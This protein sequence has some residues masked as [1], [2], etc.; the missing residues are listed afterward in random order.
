VSDGV[1]AERLS[2]LD[3]SFLAVEG[4]TSPMHVGWVAAFDPPERGRRPSFDELLA[5]I[6]GRMGRAPRFRQKL[7]AVPLGVHDPV[8]VDDAAF[9]PAAHLLRAEG[10]KLDAVVDE[11]LSTPLRRDRP[12]WQITVADG[13][14]DGRFALIGKMHH[15]L[16]DG[17]AIVELGNLLLDPEPR[18]RRFGRHE[19]EPAPAP[20]P[21][22]RLGRAIADRIGD[23]AAL[24]VA[25]ARLAS[26]AAVVRGARTL[27]H[28]VLPPARSSLLNRPGSARRHHVRVTRSLD[29]VRAVRRR[30]SVT[31]NDVALAACAGA[32]RRFA[33]RRGEVA[34]PLKIMVPADVR[35]SEDAGTGNRISFVFLELPCH[36]P[37]PVQRLQRI[38]AATARRRRDG[39]A[40]GLDAAL[41]M[42]ARTP[43]PLQHA[44]AHAFAHPRLFN[45][46]IS[47]VP[48]PAV[49]RYL[50]G[51]RLREVWSA[52]P[53]AD[54]HAL[55]IG[56][57]T[58]AGTACFGLFADAETLPDADSL[59]ADLEAALDELVALV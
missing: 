6:A 38:G 1:T 34:A 25:P 13:L 19:W 4:P 57:V 11:V 14:E 42:L 29:E 24:A 3:A 44:L 56:V 27:A 59:G 28:V 32:L 16:V 36:E 53:L 15:C 39:D 18:G 48:G 30:F 45:L 7:A 50:R 47:S 12:L 31:P 33:E 20:T 2:P 43:G 5:H 17:A 37:D 10:A 51:C 49:P 46:T 26:P 9:D 58:V 52:V 41:G 40:D 23:A 55:S 8:W 21:G 54:R 22:V 35:S